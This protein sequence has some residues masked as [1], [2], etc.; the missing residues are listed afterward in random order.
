MHEYSLVQ[1]LVERVEREARARSAVAVHRLAV[2][3]GELSGVD[4]E[5]F[6]T[7]YETFR[8]GTICASAPLA[9]TTVAASWSCPRCAR[10]IARGAAL[11]CPDCDVPARLDDGGDALTLDAIDLEVP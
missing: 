9:L 2:R 5:L 11:R 10:P 8:A 3:V 1:S 6:R 4:P 7:A